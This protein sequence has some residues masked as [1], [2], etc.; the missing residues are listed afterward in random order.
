MLCSRCSE[1]VQPVVAVDIDGTL[2][3]YHGHFLRFAQQYLG[4]GDEQLWT[5]R[6]KPGFRQWFTE[7]YRVG[8]QVYRDIKLAY[9]QGGM[10]RSMPA[11]P[12]AARLCQAVLTEGAELWLTTTRPY[13]RLDNIDPDTREWLRRNG[14]KD[15]TGLVYDDDKYHRLAELVDKRRIVAVVDDLPEMVEQAAVAVHWRVPIQ[16]R[17]RWNELVAPLGVETLD[18][19]TTEI[20]LRIRDWNDHYKEES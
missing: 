6:G 1:R 5:Y 13:L 19:I 16:R 2:G 14:I 17:T 10:K 3:D 7:T 8:D 20:I 15:Y 12:G 11:Y 4:R 18:K 9:R